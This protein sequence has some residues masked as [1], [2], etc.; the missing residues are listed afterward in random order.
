MLKRVLAIVVIALFVGFIGIQ[1]TLNQLSDCPSTDKVKHLS[2]VYT[3]EDGQEVKVNVDTHETTQG[4][5]DQME[6]IRQ[7]GA[8]GGTDMSLSSLTTEKGGFEFVI[9]GADDQT[10]RVG[11]P[12]DTHFCQATL[13]RPFMSE[14]QRNTVGGLRAPMGELASQACEEAA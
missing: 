5:V 13:T 10:V 11:F 1:W 12:Q 14:E 7:T 9:A 4:P 3:S 6:S 2:C 8:P